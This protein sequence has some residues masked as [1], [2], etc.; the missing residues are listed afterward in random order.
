MTKLIFNS[1]F[2]PAENY[3]EIANEEAK[4]YN[5]SQLVSTEAEMLR[6]SI[7]GKNKNIIL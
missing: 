7:K 4:K 1:D 6:N 5:F 3:L 2:K